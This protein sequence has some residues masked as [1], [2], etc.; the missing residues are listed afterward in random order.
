MGLNATIHSGPESV[1][2]ALPSVSVEVKAWVYYDPCHLKQSIHLLDNFQ[3]M[4]MDIF[5]FG[6]SAIQIR[7][8]WDNINHNKV[9]C[10]G[11]AE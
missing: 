9:A 5:P 3:P 4:V 6:D 7:N 8:V 11:E 1:E 10:C 2:V